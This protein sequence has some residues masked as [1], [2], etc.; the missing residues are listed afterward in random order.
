MVRIVHLVKRRRH[1]GMKACLLDFLVLH[2]M[3][4]HVFIF[5]EKLKTIEGAEVA[6]MLVCV[7][8]V[9]STINVVVF[10]MYYLHF[11]RW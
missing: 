10:Y 5:Y 9:Y 1:T 3:M 7:R 2:T 11:R 4:V 6:F 8:D